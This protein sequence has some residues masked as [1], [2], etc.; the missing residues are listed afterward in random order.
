VDNGYDFL[1]EM[2]ADFS[3]DPTSIRDFMREISDC[4]VVVG[5]RYV[6]GGGADG[7]SLTRRV[8]SAGAN[9]YVRLVLGL[10]LRDCTGGFKIF[11]VG[12]LKGLDLDH[13][14]SDPNIYDGPETLLRLTKA[15]ARIKEIPI[16]FRERAAGKSKLDANKII[17]NML[18]H[19]NLRMK[20]GGA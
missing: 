6:K 5:S 14:Y 3:H 19:L 18:N 4:D 20:L 8:I 1:V 11:R 15:G 2:D 7:W 10:S 16:R 12:A 17:R 9:A 13:Y